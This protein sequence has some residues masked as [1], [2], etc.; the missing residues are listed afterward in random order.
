MF[1]SQEPV[2]VLSSENDIY[3]INTHLS[4]AEDIYE[5]LGLRSYSDNQTPRIV[6]LFENADLQ[7][8]QKVVFEIYNTIDISLCT[9]DG[10]GNRINAYALD[11]ERKALYLLIN[12]TIYMYNFE[13][14]S[15]FEIE[16]RKGQRILN[17]STKNWKGKSCLLTYSIYQNYKKDKNLIHYY[18]LE[19]QNII[20]HKCWAL[21]TCDVQ[22]AVFSFINEE[23]FM[24][25]CHLLD[26]TIYSIK[27]KSDDYSE[28]Y[29]LPDSYC[30]NNMFLE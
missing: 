27:A 7:F 10:Y 28:F 20:A 5:C 25:F 15:F 1:E 21:K 8:E 29:M 22:K 24:Y 18:V 2:A 9:P 26:N 17:I 12:N 30:I 4:D 23:S 14:S 16:K 11:K 19:E 13:N 6:E 3:I